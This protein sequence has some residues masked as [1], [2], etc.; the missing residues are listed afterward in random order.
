M[1]QFKDIHGKE[2][3]LSFTH[4]E[5]VMNSP[6]VKG[7]TGRRAKTGDGGGLNPLP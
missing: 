3:G 6:D 4:E 5:I 7:A 1:Y 2:Y